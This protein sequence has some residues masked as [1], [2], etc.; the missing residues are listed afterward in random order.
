MSSRQVM[1]GWCG[2]VKMAL[3]STVSFLFAC[4]LQ[5]VIENREVCIYET[6]TGIDY[7]RKKD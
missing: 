2:L 7:E 4:V 1:L 5:I 6:V 3:V